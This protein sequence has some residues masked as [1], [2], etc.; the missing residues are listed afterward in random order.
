[1]SIWYKVTAWS[2][3]PE[4]LNVIK[5]GKRNLFVTEV[6]SGR[7]LTRTVFKRSLQS[8]CF[9]NKKEAAQWL[10]DYLT[11]QQDKHLQE[12]KKYTQRIN[13]LK[14]NYRL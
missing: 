13:K 14:N 4:K 12:Y 9:I 5:E 2:K 8:A 3:Y 7:T 10:V 6:V 1:M 11:T